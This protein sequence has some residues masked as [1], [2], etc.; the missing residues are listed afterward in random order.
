MGIGV[1]LLVAMLMR[2]RILFW[3]FFLYEG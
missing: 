1:T 2:K 3:V